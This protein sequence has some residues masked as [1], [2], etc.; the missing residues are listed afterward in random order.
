MDAAFRAWPNPQS[1]NVVAPVMESVSSFI[2]RFDDIGFVMPLFM[3]AACWMTGELDIFF[4]FFVMEEDSVEK[5]RRSG[6]HVR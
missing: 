3:E 2:D 1:T 4:I 6:R 5:L